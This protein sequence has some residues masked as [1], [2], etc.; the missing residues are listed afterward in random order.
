MTLPLPTLDTLAYDPLVAQA[1]DLLPYL[2][3]EWTDHNAHD[4]GITLIELLAWITEAD[5]YR[6]DQLAPRSERSF[7]RLVGGGVRPAQVARA[8]VAFAANASLSLLAGAPVRS[9]DGKV[10]FQTGT[11][12]QV[13]D[14]RAVLRISAIG[15]IWVAHGLAGPAFLPFGA[16]PAVGDAFYL[17]LDRALSP[18][19]SRARLFA[20]GADLAAD[21]ATWQALRAARPRAL[22]RDQAG[23][24]GCVGW[25]EHH[26]ARVVWEY[27]DGVGWQALPGL[28]DG[29]RALSLSGP[30]RF[31]VPADMRVGGVAGHGDRWFIRCRLVQ[32]AFDC[33]PRLKA[34]LLNAVL[35]RHVADEPARQLRQSNGHA[36]QRFDLS[37]GPI[38]PGSTRLTLTLPNGT[39]TQW[40]ERPDFDRSGALARH[41]WVDATRC[42]VVFGDGRAGRVPE[43]GGA[44]SVRWKT[45]GGAGGNVPASTLSS[46]PG[47]L[48]VTQ[49]FAAWGGAEA[50]TLGEAKARTVRSIAN[51]RCAVTLHDLEAVAL[52]VPGAPVAR[53][54]AVAGFHP[55]LTHFDVAGCVTVVVLSPCVRSQPD[56]TPALCRAVRRHLDPRRPVATELHVTGPAWTT[57]SVKARLHARGG[58]SA[59]SLQAEALRRLNAFFDPL[60]GG[61][62]GDGWP[63]GRP[64][65]R[66]E[67]LAL[68]D[69]LPSVVAVDKLVL[70]RDGLADDHCN[71]LALCPHGLVRSGPHEFEV[72]PEM[73]R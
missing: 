72:S 33:A 47:G 12:F 50:E 8:L 61:P 34:L 35:A 37:R 15:S 62:Q 48:S 59:T 54:H 28:F 13:V 73:S 29:T 63:F 27:F 11:P 38:V 58:L 51:A 16:R 2:S 67:V 55:Q 18:A 68:L 32:G 45:G 1:R 25:R 22:R 30:V 21:E 10:R 43:A 19:G 17:G 66:A 49:D 65:Y 4:P 69:E 9:A 26:G 31:R 23:G 46:A 44:V 7:L 36:L 57:V 56:P 53:A 5:S 42:Q 14:A 20:V 41:Y 70:V 52:R 40:A 64:V 3:P 71:N 24:C 39:L 6:L 60:T